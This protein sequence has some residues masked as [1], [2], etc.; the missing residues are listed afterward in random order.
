[1]RDS[2]RTRCEILGTPRPWWFASKARLDGSS[3]VEFH[4]ART[5]QRKRT[6]MRRAHRRVSSSREEKESLEA[7][8][9]R[10][11]VQ[12][13]VS[14]FSSG[15]KRRSRSSGVDW[16][17]PPRFLTPGS[18]R[19]AALSDDVPA[20]SLAESGRTG[21]GTRDLPTGR[22][23]GCIRKRVSHWAERKRRRSLPANG[24]AASTRPRETTGSSRSAESSDNTTP[25]RHPAKERVD[26]W[27]ML[28]RIVAWTILCVVRHVD[29]FA[30][31]LLLCISPL[32]IKKTIGSISARHWCAYLTISQHRDRVSVGD[33]SHYVHIS[34]IHN[35]LS[36][37]FLWPY[38]SRR[39][40]GNGSPRINWNSYS[41]PWNRKSL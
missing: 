5:A 30:S 13:E 24:S 26:V 2:R 25:C 39:I 29:S 3:P 4:R 37:T 17:V 19:R 27:V 38:I 31:R 12:K 14:P 32:C 28:Q 34:Q 10:R 22:G 7:G 9:P 41:Q 40:T 6:G 35:L 36:R 20:G 8:G 16:K 15:R 23:P 21:G 1:M 18:P 11:Y 33:R